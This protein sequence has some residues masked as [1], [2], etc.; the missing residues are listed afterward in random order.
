MHSQS[1]NIIDELGLGSLILSIKFLE[2]EIK[3][4]W[5]K[6]FQSFL[7]RHHF[8]IIELLLI[9]LKAL[10]ALNYNLNYIHPFHFLQLAMLKGIVF[11][12]DKKASINSPVNSNINIVPF[13]M[14]EITMENVSYLLYHPLYLALACVAWT[15]DIYNLDKWNVLLEKLINVELNIIEKE[16]YF[17]KR[18]CIVLFI[19][20]DRVFNSKKA[21]LIIKPKQIKAENDLNDQSNRSEVEIQLKY[22]QFKS[23][24]LEKSKK[25]IQSFTLK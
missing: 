21:S 16:V 8:T 6:R 17:V 23:K 19:Y 22:E 18:Y 11:N 25:G 5:L 13:H 10:K 1:I 12:I 2:L 15:R 20:Y 14:L 9:E 3:N 7:D 4:Q 24:S